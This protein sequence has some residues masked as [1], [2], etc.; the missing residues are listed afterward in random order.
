MRK[1]LAVSFLAF[2]APALLLAPT[3]LPAQSASVADSSPFRPLGLPAPNEYRTGAGR[4]GPRYWQ[5]RVDYRIAATLDPVRNEVRGRETVHYVNRSPDSLRYLWF[6]VE[7]NI[8]APTSVTN[9]LNQPPLV[10]LGSTFDFSCQGF[11]A[12]E[13]STPRALVVRQ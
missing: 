5:Q 12:A 8:C 9:Q 3:S 11:V 1:M 10:F 13:H 4:P 2:S 7:Q 6:H